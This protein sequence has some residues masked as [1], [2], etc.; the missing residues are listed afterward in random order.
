MDLKKNRFNLL[1]F[2]FVFCTINCFFVSCSDEKTTEEELL[3]TISDFKP[4]EGVTGDEVI[5]TGSNFGGKEAVYFNETKVTDFISYSDKKIIVKVPAGAT[6]GPISVVQGDKKYFSKEDFTC[7]VNVKITGLSSSTGLPG[8]TI[9]IY[10]ENFYNLSLSQIKVLFNNVSAEV[11]SATSKEINVVIPQNAESGPITV[12]FEDI[13][14]IVGPN[15]T[16]GEKPEIQ[17]VVFNLWEYVT[18]YGHIKVETEPENGVGETHHGTYIIYKFT[19]PSSGKYN[20]ETMASTNQSYNT[21]VN[22][23]IATELES[24]KDKVVDNSL[25]RQVTK[26]G[27]NT[28]EKLQVGAFALNSGITYYLKITFLAEGTPWVA[29][30]SNL[31]V[32]FAPDQSVD[33]IEVGS[34]ASAYT[35]YQN[36]F[37]VGTMYAPFT[38]R[39][40]FDP[41]YIKVKDQ[42]LE[43]YFNQNA[44]LQDDR[45]ERRGAEV[46]CDFK[47]TTEG[48][49]GFK[50]FL[51]E[52]KFPKNTVTHIAQ[53]FQN[54]DCNSWAGSL[55]IV[56]ENLQ[57]YRR[58][59]C[60]DATEE[61]VTKIPW[62]TW[63][64]I[65]LHFKVSMMNTGM[66]QVW[67]GD[68]PENK[69]TY[70]ATKINFGFGDWVNGETLDDI[71]SDS[72]LN[73]DYISCKFGMYCFDG[74]DRTIRFDDLKALEKNPVGAF[75]IV[76]PN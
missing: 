44:L 48:W 26:Q 60:G 43:F 11:V 10:G 31:K 12:V 71:K 34:G 75:D 18:T 59:Y 4:K 46:V 72:N 68:A 57:V 64:P 69:P 32:T 56:N 3:P 28:F 5:I 15:F 47:T 36:D 54:G 62:D 19:V 2:A 49:Y 39:W 7:I 30:I 1:S 41:N 13:T 17:D 6:T 40:A 58:S 55:S 70:N 16:I 29:N 73:P 52:G 45:R 20:V 50:I 61:I 65:V 27:W 24:L 25:S 53:I 23:D 51:P 38:P 76:K 67:V 8:E 21:Y 33:A 74:G 66:V 42:Y 35:I 37:N 22:V 9:S 63:V 14:T